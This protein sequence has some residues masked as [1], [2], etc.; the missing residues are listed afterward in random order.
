MVTVM[1]IHFWLIER[2]ISTVCVIECRTIGKG[3]VVAVLN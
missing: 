2:D 1:L 3:K